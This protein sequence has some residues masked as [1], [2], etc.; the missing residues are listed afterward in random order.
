MGV[1]TDAEILAKID[2]IV[3]SVKLIPDL[4]NTVLSVLDILTANP[5]LDFG[6]G[7]H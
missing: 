7:T 3:A 4:Q 5:M 2:S 6:K 1:A